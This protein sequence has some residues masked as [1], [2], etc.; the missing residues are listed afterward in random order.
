MLSLCALCSRGLSQSMRLAFLIV[1]VNSEIR[2]LPDKVLDNNYSGNVVDIC[3][4]GALTD[5][6]FRFQC[7]VWYL[8][9]NR[10]RLQRLQPRMQHH[11]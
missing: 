4:V 8:E 1:G 2:L 11:R 5:R 9:Q 6:D 3:P 10:F 7:R